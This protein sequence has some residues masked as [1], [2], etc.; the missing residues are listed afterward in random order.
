MERE[1]PVIKIA[2][3]EFLI[4]VENLQLVQRE[5]RKNTISIEEMHDGG[6]G[7]NFRYCRNN[8]TVQGPGWQKPDLIKVYIPEFVEMDPEGMAA[9]YGLSLS[10]LKG[11]SDFD[12]IV[13]QEALE[14]RLNGRLTT[15][16]IAGHLFY[17]DIPMDMLRPHDDFLSKGIRFDDI[18]FYVDDNADEYIIPYHPGRH[19]FQDI[20]L[21]NIVEFPKDLI[22]VA[23]PHERFLDPVAINRKAGYDL[24]A[25]LKYRPVQSHFKA[26][27]VNVKE[28]VLKRIM[29]DNRN[30]KE[31][32]EVKEAKSKQ[33]RRGL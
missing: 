11:K 30:R 24:T 26:R 13:D 9:K 21:D 8:K 7:Y 28:T 1:L 18:E 29:D 17:V 31:K 6:N 23:F 10:E 25:G 5:N 32:R 22:L 20:D 15:V 12:I 2:E 27:I 3:T 14:K 4:D 33:R 16:D 19:E